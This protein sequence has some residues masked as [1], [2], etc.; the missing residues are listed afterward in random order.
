MILGPFSIKNIISKTSNIKL[1]LY[2]FFFTIWPGG[3]L[4][5]SSLYD[6]GMPKLQGKTNKGCKSMKINQILLQIKKFGLAHLLTK[7]LASKLKRLLQAIKP[8]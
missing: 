5:I 3:C 2:Y 6:L 7:Y 8:F 4:K 1:L